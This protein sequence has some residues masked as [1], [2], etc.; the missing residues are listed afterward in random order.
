VR[1]LASD[2]LLPSR[3]RDV[4]VPEEA[5]LSIAEATIGDAAI[6]TNPRPAL[7]EEVIELLRAAW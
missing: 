1:S 6:F 4:D 3:L 7:L 5:L 2:C